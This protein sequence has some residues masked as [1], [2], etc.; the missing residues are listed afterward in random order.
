MIPR[1]TKIW[2]NGVLQLLNRKIALIHLD[3][4]KTILLKQR[5]I[6]GMHHNDENEKLLGHR[7]SIRGRICKNSLPN[8]GSFGQPYD[9]QVAN[10]NLSS[11]ANSR[12]DQ[13]YPRS[14]GIFT[15][16]S[17]LGIYGTGPH[18]AGSIISYAI[19]IN[20]ARKEEM[21]VIHYGNNFT[22]KSRK[23]I[24][25]LTLSDGNPRLYL[26]AKSI[27]QPR[28][29]YNLNDGKWHHIVVSMPRPSCNLS[30]VVMYVDGQS[31]STKA[32]NDINI[33]FVTSGRL[34][35]GGFGYSHKGF[36]TVFPHLSPFLGKIGEFFL[37]SRALQRKDVILAMVK[38]W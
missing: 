19:W 30:D 21:I 4:K 22:A 24:Y 38:K 35:I 28:K 34:S 37:W 11:Q 17:R 18:S 3:F 12:N 9:A 26:S 15:K 33:F 10:V 25:T 32:Q 36:D 14:Y 20:T 1:C 13:A 6:V 8:E 23:N 5:Q 7:I 29:N 31:V 27:L 2:S 16:N